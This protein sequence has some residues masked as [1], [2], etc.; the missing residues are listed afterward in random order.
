[1]ANLYRYLQWRKAH[2]PK[3][4]SNDP[5]AIAAKENNILLVMA[6]ITETME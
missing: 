2:S 4:R 3:R 6:D 5:I 1:M